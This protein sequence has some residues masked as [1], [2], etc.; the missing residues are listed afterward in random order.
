MLSGKKSSN[1]QMPTLTFNM[2]DFTHFDFLKDLVPQNCF[3]GKR[4]KVPGYTSD[5]LPDYTKLLSSRTTP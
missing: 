1:V 5:E 4:D 2:T 3:V